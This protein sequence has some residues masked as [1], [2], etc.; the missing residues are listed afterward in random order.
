MTFSKRKKGFIFSVVASACFF[1]QCS[2]H[3]WLKSLSTQAVDGSGSSPQGPS[4][5][6]RKSLLRCFPFRRNPRLSAA[7][8]LHF[9]AASIE[10]VTLVQTHSCWVTETARTSAENNAKTVRNAFGFSGSPSLGDFLLAG[11]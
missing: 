2:S 6:M 3:L 7:T 11:S 1:Q 9:P 8:L 5:R 10:N 4:R